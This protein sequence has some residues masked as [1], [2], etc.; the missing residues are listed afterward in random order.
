MK[1]YI[2]TLV[3]IMLL[4]VTIPVYAIAKDD[5]DYI[6]KH[7]AN[8]IKLA[9]DMGYEGYPCYTFSKEQIKIYLKKNNIDIDKLDIDRI[10]ENVFVICQKGVHSATYV[11]HRNELIYVVNQFYARCVKYPELVILKFDDVKNETNKGQ[12]KGDV[13]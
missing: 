12:Q 7:V 2:A 11:R 9:F 1:K 4:F 5:V 13:K 6:C 3:F 10:Q 8:L